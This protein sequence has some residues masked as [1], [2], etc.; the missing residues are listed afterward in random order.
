MDGIDEPLSRRGRLHGRLLQVLGA[1]SAIAAAIALW[2]FGVFSDD[3]DRD[4]VG[5]V[6]GLVTPSVPEGSEGSSAA[7]SAPAADATIESPS[8]SSAAASA[9]PSDAASDSLRPSE[10]TAAEETEESAA[11]SGCTARLTLDEAWEDSADVTVEVVN[12]G[13]EALVSWE[14]DLAVE[15]MEIYHF[16]N[17]RDLGGGRYG[18]ED[19]NAQLDPGEDAVAGFQ[20]EVDGGMELPESAPCT[21][22]S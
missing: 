17:M 12:V 15:G 3:P 5:A 16:W 21:T 19:W 13:G 6:E 14:V 1:V 10:T 2:Q 8:E 11:G 22:G 18:S 4:P 20:A 7:D 9:D